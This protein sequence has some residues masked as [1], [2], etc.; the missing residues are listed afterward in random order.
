MKVLVLHIDT[1]NIHYNKVERITQ[2]TDGYTA[3]VL[4][5]WQMF[6]L[7]VTETKAESPI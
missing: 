7:T 1:K 2:L 4:H 3:S 5:H 6:N